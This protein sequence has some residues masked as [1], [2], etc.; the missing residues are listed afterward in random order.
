MAHVQD[1]G[2]DS[3]R[4]RWRARYRAPD[5]RERSRSFDR[6]VD[7]QRWLDEQTAAMVTGRWIDPN[8]RKVTVG[9]W[10]ED[11]LAGYQSRRPSTVRQA[12]THLNKIREEFGAM[13]LGAV[14][15]SHVRSWTAKLDD[16]GYATSYVHALH[17]RLSQIMTDAVHDRLIAE[18]PCS[19]RTSPPTGDQ[20]PYVATTEQVWELYEG[21]GERL[22]V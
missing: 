10:C 12:R 18:N 3:T 7:A 9:E 17:A 19:R 20:R 16:E 8:A 21:F 1:R 11:W 4:K 13:P 6:K 15:P 2:A 5:G 22:A 14:R